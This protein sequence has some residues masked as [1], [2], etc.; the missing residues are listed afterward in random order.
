MECGRS[1]RRGRRFVFRAT[2]AACVLVFAVGAAT[3]VAFYSLV[4]ERWG[5]GALEETRSLAAPVIEG[6]ARYQADH[7]EAP[8]SLGDLVPEYMS[9]VP[10]V[11]AGSGELSYARA[12]DNRERYFLSVKSRHF[13]SMPGTVIS[14]I[15]GYPDTYDYRQSRG[16]WE[17]DDGF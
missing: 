10:R 8:R 14:M 16:V 13:G 7:G 6:I 12:I 1:S 9:E 3:A 11:P 5:E 2:L 15:F 4:Y 17:L